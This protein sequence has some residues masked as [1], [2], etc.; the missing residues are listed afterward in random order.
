MES[1][2]PT[3]E[4]SERTMN[5][6]ALLASMASVAL[7]W[8]LFYGKQNR[9]Q[10]L[11]VGLWAPTFLGIASYLRIAGIDTDI[12]KLTG[13]RMTKRMEEAMEAQIENAM[14]QQ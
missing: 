12:D 11:F 6:P 2:N 10:G 1:D 4:L 8:Y 3:P 13:N 14:E 9:L 5:Y 7:S